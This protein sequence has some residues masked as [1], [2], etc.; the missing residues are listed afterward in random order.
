MAELGSLHVSLSLDASSFNGSISQ[1]NRQ[2]RAMGGELQS[3]RA[4]GIDYERSIDGLSQKQNVLQRSLNASSIK[5]QE[6]RKRYDELVASGKASDAQ[7]ERA[8]IAVNRAQAEYNR[9]EKE[10]ADVTRELKIQSS[11]WTQAGQRLEAVGGKLKSIGSGMASIGKD[12]S[13]KV[14]AP[15]VA[16]GAGILKAGIDFEASMS[17]VQALS[18][19]TGAEMAKLE[20]QA[21]ELGATTAFSA[22]Q[23]ADGMAFLAMAGWETSDIIAGMPGLLDLAASGALDLGRAA[24][25]TSNIMSAFSIEASKAGHVADVLAAAASNANT[26]VEQ[27]GLA[28]TY[29]APVAN[30]LGWTL[31][32]SAAAVMAM[33]DAGIQGEKAGAAFATSLQR[34]ANPTKAMKNVM[35][36]LN[37]TFFD[38]EGQIKPLPQLIGELEQ[39]TQTLTS[40]QKAAALSTIFGAEAYKNW[41]VLLETGSDS[42]ASNTKM[43]VEADGAAKQ[44]A[45]TMMDNAKGAIVEFKSAIE[46][47]SIQLSE[48]L[49]PFV[50]QAVD[51]LTEM[52][53]G[54]GELSPATQKT[55]LAIGGVVAAAGPLLVIGGSIMSGIGGLVTT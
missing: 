3:I 9:L 7:I 17:K 26:N 36:E 11:M 29:L 44:M 37:I 8:A 15:I 20:E 14:T 35:E 2:M 22:S 30:T 23:A 25:I 1:V 51:K 46:G 48:H 34:L 12:L 39:A 18:G 53:R 40:E 16:M 5:L 19:A 28:M 13:M 10:L 55:I 33:S 27:M 24:D 41:A 54:F 31:E 4:K 45:D 42:L 49:L 38:A 6:T 43:L 32:E 21:K 50:T 52:V 47:I